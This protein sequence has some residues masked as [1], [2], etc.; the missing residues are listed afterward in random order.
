MEE[1]KYQGHPIQLVHLKVTKLFIEPNLDVKQDL[2]TDTGKFSLVTGHGD[3]D[4]EDKIITVSTGAK[5]SSEDGDNPFDLDIEL[6]GIFEVDEDRFPLIHIEDWAKRNAPIILYPYLREH[7]YS[8]TTRC[9]FTGAL[10]PLL[11]VP[12]F[13]IEK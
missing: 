9:G 5:I 13:K 7:V 10:L 3:Y 12:T 2:E 6:L 11:E 4:E 8:L 1:K